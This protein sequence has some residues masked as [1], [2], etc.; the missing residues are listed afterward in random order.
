MGA[1]SGLKKA[2]GVLVLV[3]GATTLSGF[4]RSLETVFVDASPA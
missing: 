2:L 3:F 1:G 4:D